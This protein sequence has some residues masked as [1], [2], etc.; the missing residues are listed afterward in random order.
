M[1][2]NKADE[3]TPEPT[4][5]IPVV[6][7]AVV[8]VTGVEMEL[9]QPEVTVEVSP[10]PVVEPISEL[11]AALKDLEDGKIIPVLK[12]VEHVIEEVATEVAAEAS[13]LFDQFA[14]VHGVTP[15]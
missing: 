2:K 1:A 9:T 6:Q 5:E 14:R 3:G 7:D 12:A 8:P 4:L 11:K 10:A 13:A 15:Q